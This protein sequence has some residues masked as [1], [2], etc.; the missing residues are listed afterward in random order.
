[1]NRMPLTA[2]VGQLHTSHLNALL[3]F[4]GHHCSKAPM[5]AVVPLSLTLPRCSDKPM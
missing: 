3:H 5:C 2:A 4:P 1:M